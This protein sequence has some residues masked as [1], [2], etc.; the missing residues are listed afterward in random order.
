VEYRISA[1]AADTVDTTLRTAGLS[2]RFGVDVRRMLSQR[3][4]FVFQLGGVTGNLKQPGGDISVRGF[5][6]GAHLEYRP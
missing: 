6:V 1:Q 3:A 4:A 2:W 5:R